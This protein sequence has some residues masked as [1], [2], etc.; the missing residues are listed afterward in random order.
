MSPIAAAPTTGPTTLGINGTA[1]AQAF[2]ATLGIGKTYGALT[3]VNHQTMTQ[4][5]L[6]APTYK[7]SPEN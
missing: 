2:I 1:A 5:R 6:Y 7:L 4:C 3:S